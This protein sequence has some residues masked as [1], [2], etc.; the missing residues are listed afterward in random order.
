MKILGI[1][2]ARGGSKGIPRKNLKPL[3]GKALLQYTV[4]SAKASQLLS[5]VVL[6]S[7]DAEIQQLARDLG[8]EVPFSRPLSLAGDDTPT[9][10]VIKHALEHFREE[11]FDAVCLLQVT[12]PFREEGSIDRAIRKFMA[13]GT[14]SLVSVL[15]VPAEYNPHWV[16]EPDA[17][18]HL[19]TATGEKNIIPRRQDLPK[20]YHRDGS[21]YLTRAQVILEQNSLYGDSMAFMESDP[22]F[23]VNIDT[24][25][26]W[27]QAE[28]LAGKYNTLCAE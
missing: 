18:G 1:I 25:T 10:E 12:S 17:Q 24:P 20:A 4:D 2:P 14:D 13:E 16:F 15:E 8:L 22:E 7:E 26:D 5:R 3:A 27:K 21:I 11:K 19:K 28:I 9:L 6:S 23:H